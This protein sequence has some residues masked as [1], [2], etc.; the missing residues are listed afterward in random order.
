M[1]KRMRTTIYCLSAMLLLAQVA[2]SAE[3]LPQLQGTVVDAYGQVLSGAAIE[4]TS[5][6]GT[7]SLRAETTKEGRFQFAELIPGKYTLS[8]KLEAFVDVQREVDVA[9]GGVEE[10]TI[11]LQVI[12]NDAS[13]AAT[14][15]GKVTDLSG[16]VVQGARVSAIGA[17]SGVVLEGASSDT[18]GK[19]K[20]D[21]AD[22]GQYFLVAVKPGYVSG[23]YVRTT[24]GKKLF[25]DFVLQEDRWK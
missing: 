23:V 11:S 18:D 1:P 12:R 21:I 5:S 2:F 14:V 24:D 9:A 7:R 19:F 6:G 8:V 22:G 25:V 20:F 3:S 13:P 16:R 15:S 4:L 17:F 10:R